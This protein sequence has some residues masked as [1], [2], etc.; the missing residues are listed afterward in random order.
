MILNRQREVRVALSPLEKF[1]GR[2]R[3]ELRLN[4]REVSVC[5]VSDGEIAKL[6]RKYR[7]K[8]KPTDV[9]SFSAAPNGKSRVLGDSQMA[10]YLG[11]IAISPQT[12]RRNARRYGRTLPDELRILILHGVLHL[13]GYDHE[14]DGGEMERVEARLRQRMG[15]T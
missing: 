5:L 1:L 14:A 3:K 2:V 8:A 13:M 4:G 7:G 12:A 6:N 11:D 15:L 9:L 10:S